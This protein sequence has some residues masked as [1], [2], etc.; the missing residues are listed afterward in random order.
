M[1]L[2]ITYA[3]SDNEEGNFDYLI[4]EL[5]AFGINVNYDKI[6]LIPGQRLWSQIAE[7]ITNPNTKAWAYLITP[8]SL[9]SQPCLEELAYALDKALST[10]NGNFPLIGLV[11]ARIPFNEIPLALKVRLC[12]SLTDPNWKE[13]IKA[14][15]EIRPVKKID[16]RQTKYI[17]KISQEF[18]G[19]NITT[20]IEIRPRFEELHFWRFAIPI[21]S[22]IIRF[23]FGPANS[24]Q[25]NGFMNS[26]IE[27]TLDNVNGQECKFVGACNALSPGTS[28]YIFVDTG[29]PEFI[30]FGFANQAMGFPVHLE[31]QKLK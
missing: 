9:S 7:R 23:G 5:Q 27:G 25:T 28:A 24:G 15:M 17:Y 6:A 13:Q 16:T 14:G 1:S 29:I 11:T 10:K 21:S 18:N 19:I 26:V 31:T 3:W 20:I 4:Q 8:N 2:W 12:I 30:A 22:N